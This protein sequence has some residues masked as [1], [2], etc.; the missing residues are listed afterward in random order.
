MNRIQA[1][2]LLNLD[3]SA[4]LTT[5]KSA[6]RSLSRAHHPDAGGSASKFIEIKLA[7]DVASEYCQVDSRWEKEQVSKL[8]KWRIDFRK[9]W[10]NAYLKTFSQR[11]DDGL[12]FNT[13][14]DDFRRGFIYPPQDWFTH[15]IFGESLK[16][17]NAKAGSLINAAQATA[18]DFHAF[19][20][21]HLLRI[22]PNPKFSESYAKKYFELEFAEKWVFYL[23][24]AN[25]LLAV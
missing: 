7:Y 2:Q 19:Y 20:R 1:L 5:V 25:Q 4:D 11:P 21:A 3:S 24:P 16:L 17:P 13:C 18:E 9:R 10:L 14:I 12:H 8:P 23:P 22:A 6:Y 15:A